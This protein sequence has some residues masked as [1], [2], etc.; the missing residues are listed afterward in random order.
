MPH[1]YAFCSLLKQKGSRP[2]LTWQPWRRIVC[3]YALYAAK[4]MHSQR[5]YRGGE[6]QWCTYYWGQQGERSDSS[7]IRCVNSAE[8]KLS[9]AW[10]CWSAEASVLMAR[11][12]TSLCPGGASHWFYMA[13]PPGGVPRVTLSTDCDVTALQDSGHCSARSAHSALNGSSSKQKHMMVSNQI[14]E[15]PPATLGNSRWRSQQ[16]R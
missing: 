5:F 9:W 4:V 12:W 14:F 16:T 10:G 2:K 3:I 7:R 11:G 15:L 8:L 1:C 13:A 6:K